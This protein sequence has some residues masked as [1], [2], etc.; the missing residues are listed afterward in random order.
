MKMT[1]QLH[2]KDNK[3]DLLIVEKLHSAQVE[4]DNIN[5]ELEK[6]GLP[7][8]TVDINMLSIGSGKKELKNKFKLK[9]N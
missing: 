3:D 9:T 6:L 2:E 8:L 1:I 7:K 4:I 5:I